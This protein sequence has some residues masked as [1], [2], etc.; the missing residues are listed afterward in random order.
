VTGL[1]VK[2]NGQATTGGHTLGQTFKFTNAVSCIIVLAA[3]TFN[4]SSAFAK[5]YFGAIAISPSNKA[6]G[7][8]FDYGN[9]WKAEQVALKKCS[10]YAGD[11]KI[12]TWFRNACGAVSVGANGGWGAD[13]GKNRKQ[14][15]WKS[16]KMC[17]K[18]DSY[19]KVKKTICT[20]H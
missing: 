16:R 17:K 18:Y 7:W 3:L 5:D 12:A 15:R 6:M 10:K 14:A 9:R 13:W 4:T 1:N 20:R 19:C 11:C 2:R 8:S